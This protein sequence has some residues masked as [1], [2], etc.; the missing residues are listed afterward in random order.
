MGG[1][2]FG[3]QAAR[4]SIAEYEAL[5][6]HLRSRLTPFFEPVDTSP[7]LST[8]SSHGDIDLL[9]GWT[10]VGWPTGK[11]RAEGKV[12][13]QDSNKIEV[14]DEDKKE[15]GA[16]KNNGEAL[17][18]QTGA[19]LSLANTDS[20]ASSPAPH[21]YDDLGDLLAAAGLSSITITSPPESLDTWCE[22]VTRHIGGTHWLRL[23]S[24]MSVSVPMAV[25][26]SALAARPEL[27]PDPTASMEPFVPFAFVEPKPTTTRVKVNH[28]SESHPFADLT[29]VTF[30]QVDLVFLPP[31]G[32]HFQQWTHAYSASVLLLSQLVRRASGCNDLILHGHCAVLKFTPYPLCPKVE[33]HLTHDAAELCTYLG[34]DYGK[35]CAM[36]AETLD[37]VFSWLADCAPKSRAA[38]GLRRMAKHGL[39]EGTYRTTNR[40]SRQPVL[41]EFGTWLRARGWVPDEGERRKPHVGENATN[42]DVPAAVDT[43]A[44]VAPSAVAPPP[45][46]SSV[47]ASADSNTPAPHPTSPAPLD[48]DTTA[49]ASPD[50]TSPVA[51]SPT[52]P[53]ARSP[54]PVHPDSPQPLTVV[55]A[56]LIRYWG[57]EAEYAAALAALRPAAE[58]R[59]RG[60]VREAER[61]EGKRANA[62]GGDS[63]RVASD[64]ALKSNVDN[65]DKTR[66]GAGVPPC[67]SSC[68]AM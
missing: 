37:D 16:E 56:A 7:Y 31:R 28:L 64:A 5:R 38:R 4:L 59:W 39:I 68:C 2:A 23:G 8:K 47:N 54:Q 22:I 20:T 12:H 27:Q 18:A 24:Q 40:Q 62:K 21:S 25:V 30:C 57:K 26:H 48:I 1:N 34:L 41:D 32:V 50:P 6:A 10:G 65:I 60:A 58:S 43:S 33:V 46:S 51:A 55:H 19:P 17:F 45:G 49:H 11:G 53:P 14:G 29:P 67:R 9:C 42:V 35:W 15:G 44:C 3:A 52:S 63:D 66:E 13:K 61:A 36:R